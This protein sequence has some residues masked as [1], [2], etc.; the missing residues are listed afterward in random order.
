MHRS[1]QHAH[2]PQVKE[3]LGAGLEQLLGRHY[4]RAAGIGHVIDQDRGHAL[5]VANEPHAG[6]LVRAFPLLVDE[7]KVHIE[8]VGQ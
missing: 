3:Y 7:R 5:D 8:P 1:N 2:T 4:Q 6:H